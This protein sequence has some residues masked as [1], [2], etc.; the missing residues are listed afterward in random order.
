MFTLDGSCALAHNAAMKVRLFGR[1]QSFQP[2]PRGEGQGKPA[3]PRP[4]RAGGA[5]PNPPAGYVED[6]GQQR[7]LLTIAWRDG[8]LKGLHR[9]RRRVERTA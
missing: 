7:A 5:L 4:L 9:G 1:A 2:L 6:R 3:F 8:Y